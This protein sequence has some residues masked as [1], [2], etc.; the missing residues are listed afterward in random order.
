MSAAALKARLEAV[1]AVT[2]L[3]GAPNATR[4]YPALLP[5]KPVYPACCYQL[6]SRTRV[7][8]MGVDTGLARER[9]QITTWAKGYEDASALR[10]QLRTALQRWRGTAGGQVVQDVFIETEIDLYDDE[11]LVHQLVLDVLMIVEEA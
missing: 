11:E 10:D 5:P 8:S 3:L 4:L 2:S 7:S 1:P 9:W 6:V